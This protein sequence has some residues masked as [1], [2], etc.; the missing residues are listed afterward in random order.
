MDKHRHFLDA[1]DIVPVILPVDLAAGA[2]NGLRVWMR[3]YDRIVFVFYAE[4][5]AAGEDPII[6]L[7][8]ANA[9]TGGDE[10]DLSAIRRVWQKESTGALPKDWTLISQNA[11]ATY[12]SDTGG[13]SNQLI[14]FEVDAA[15]LDVANGFDH[16]TINVADTGATTGKIGCALAICIEPR[17]ASTRP[18]AAS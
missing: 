8:Q 16:V 2:N 17:Y 14:V 11:A 6:T 12:T 9:P 7:R 13:E 1:A 5:G 10:K 15:D 4:V 3:N 18:S